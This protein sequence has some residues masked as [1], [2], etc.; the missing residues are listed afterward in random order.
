M[1][2]L[3]GRML[4]IVLY[5]PAEPG[6]VRNEPECRLVIEGRLI[7]A[8]RCASSSSSSLSVKSMTSLAGRFEEVRGAEEDDIEGSRDDAGG[9]RNVVG[10]LGWRRLESLSVTRGG[11]VTVVEGSWISRKSSNSSSSSGGV[12]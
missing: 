7:F 11:K 3:C 1:L 8:G 12:C 4:A 6:S 9:V 2:V 10:M 5:G